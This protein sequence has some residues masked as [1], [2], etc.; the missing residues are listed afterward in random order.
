MGQQGT[1]T[2]IWARLG[3]RPRAPRD[4]R[5]TW[6]YLFGAVC[7]ARGVGAA[8]ALPTVNVEAMNK[9]LIEI[10]KCVSAGAIALLVVDGAGWH[11]SPKLNVPENIVLLKLPPYAP[12]LNPVENVWEYLRGNA[13]SHQ[14]WE[15]YED[16]VDACCSAWIALVR[17]PDIVRS[18]ATRDWA[19]V[20]T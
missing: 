11:R 16:I 13:L 5:F 19:Q 3:S 4:R 17:A 14:V 6:A 2:R 8:L 9:H 18:I 12:E 7:P 10:S 20:S 15:T 1:L